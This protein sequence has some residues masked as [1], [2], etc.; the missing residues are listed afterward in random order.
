MATATSNP[1]VSGTARLTRAGTRT[2]RV[3]L[4]QNARQALRGSKKSVAVTLQVLVS[5]A[6]GNATLLQRRVS[7]RG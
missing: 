1:P 2:L 4:A 7:M 3:K 6:A 5:D